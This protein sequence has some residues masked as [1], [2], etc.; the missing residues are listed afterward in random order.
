MLLRLVTEDEIPQLWALRTRAVQLLC[1][2][3]YAV[4][5]IAV[6]TRSPVPAAYQRLVAEHSVVA[7]VCDAQIAGYAAL[8]IGG[9]E[10]APSSS[11][12]RAPDSVSASVCWRRWK[13][14]PWRAD[15]RGSRWTHL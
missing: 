8:D 7:A 15:W 5:E 13:P 3:H 9:G 10:S 4:E 1:A 14:S 11:I 12:L 6:W 2:S